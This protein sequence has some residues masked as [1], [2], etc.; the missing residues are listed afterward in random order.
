MALYYNTNPNNVNLVEFC[1]YVQPI[2]V[3][4]AGFTKT[5]GYMAHIPGVLMFMSEDNC[6]FGIINLPV[7]FDINIVA[8][9]NWFLSAKEPE[10]QEGILERIYFMGNNIIYDNMMRYYDAYKNTESFPLYYQEDD[11]YNIPGFDFHSK[12]STFDIGWLNIVDNQK[13]LY[14]IPCSKYLT[15]LTKSDTC[16]LK[17]Y[18]YIH[19]PDPMRRTAVYEIY[20]Q[21]FKLKYHV[22][23]NILIV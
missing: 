21:K 7:V 18:Q 5:A 19:V 22:Y 1:K 16:A 3:G 13:T 11:C 8:K 15:P 20:K 10:Q 2:L 14:R 4:C 17:I 23:F 6:V 9:S 12:R